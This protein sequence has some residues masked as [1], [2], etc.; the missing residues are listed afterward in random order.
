MFAELQ[1]QLDQINVMV[2]DL[3][4]PVWPKYSAEPASELETR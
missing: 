3:S 1:S 2:Y 4:G